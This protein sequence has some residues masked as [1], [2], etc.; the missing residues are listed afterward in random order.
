M[1]VSS[2]LKLF[3]PEVSEL[4]VEYYEEETKALV[5]VLKMMRFIYESFEKKHETVDRCRILIFTLNCFE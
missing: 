1:N 5:M 4:L 3:A 2:V